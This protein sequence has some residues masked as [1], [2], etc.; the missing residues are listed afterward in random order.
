MSLNSN[1]KRHMSKELEKLFD[2]KA[3]DK[4]IV[5]PDE[6]VKQSKGIEKCQNEMLKTLDV[7]M[8]KLG[9]TTYYLNERK[10]SR[11]WTRAACNVMKCQCQNLKAMKVIVKNSGDINTIRVIDMGYK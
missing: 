6:M 5:V 2:S 8:T 10:E 4:V 9:R 11:E 1:E 7:A 3:S